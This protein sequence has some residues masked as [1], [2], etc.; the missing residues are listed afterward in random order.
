M[1]F[2][3]TAVVCFVFV[4]LGFGMLIEAADVPRSAP[5]AGLP[6][7]KMLSPEALLKPDGTLALDR[8][9]SG[10]VDVRGWNVTL[11]TRRGPVLT[12]Q[13]LASDSAAASAW[14]ALADQ[15]LNGPPGAVFLKVRSFGGGQAPS[16][17]HSDAEDNQ[18]SFHSLEHIRSCFH[19][20]HS[21][22]GA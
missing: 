2:R 11:D 21:L 14:S 3:R 10:A 16:R 13:H 1:S 5:S 12:P 7:G 4:M 8:G 17:R 19:S 15:G 18:R 6:A 20:K 22:H 9:L